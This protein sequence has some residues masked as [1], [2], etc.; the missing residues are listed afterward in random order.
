MP[1]FN[2]FNK[3]NNF[4]ER[5]NKPPI[6][7]I[8]NLEENKISKNNSESEKIFNL[9]IN[10]NLNLNN[11]IY[12]IDDEPENLDNLNKLYSNNVE[13]FNNIKMNLNNRIK[14]SNEILILPE[15]KWYDELIDLSE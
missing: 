13:Y 4:G 2:T 1:E 6:K 8:H 9:K 3:F 14:L 12:V 11:Y 10:N 15:R 5:L 7:I